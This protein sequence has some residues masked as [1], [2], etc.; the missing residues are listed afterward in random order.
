MLDIGD[1]CISFVATQL[2]SVDAA[3]A[4]S[5]APLRPSGGSPRSR[6]VET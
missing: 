1:H 5:G 4:L 6:L 3:A 2:L